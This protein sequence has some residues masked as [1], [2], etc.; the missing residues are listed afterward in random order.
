MSLALYYFGPAGSTIDEAERAA[1]PAVRALP[2]DAPP[3]E[4]FD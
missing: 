3:R 1:R 2:D 4:A